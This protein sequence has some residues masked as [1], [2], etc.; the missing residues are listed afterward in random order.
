MFT[1]CRYTGELFDFYNIAL[2]RHRDDEQGYD[3]LFVDPIKRGTYGSRLS[4]SC[5]PNW[6]ALRVRWVLEMTECAHTLHSRLASSATHVMAV[7]GQFIIAVY[8]IRPIRM[9]EELCFDYNSVYVS[10]ELCFEYA[11]VGAFHMCH[12]CSNPPF[13]RI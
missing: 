10:E 7:N 8:T 4:H 3:V 12:N 13:H 2:E 9:G 11:P 5:D 1:R 6:Y